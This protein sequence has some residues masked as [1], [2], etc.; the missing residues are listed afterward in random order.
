MKTELQN[1]DEQTLAKLDTVMD[2]L[3]GEI[4]SGELMGMLD[5]TAKGGVKQTLQNCVRIFRHDP[6]FYRKIRYNILTQRP[7]IIGDVPWSRACKGEVL[8]NSDLRAIHLYIS[9]TYGITSEHVVDEAMYLVADECRYHPV[10]D[11]LN[12]LPAWDGTERIRFALHHF[13]GADTSDYTY[14]LLKFFMLGAIARVFHPGIKF[15]YMLCLVGDQGAGKSSFF[16]LLAVRDE[17]F[18]D[19]LKNLEAKDVYEKMQGHW[20][21]E[22]SEMMAAINARTNEAIKSFLSRQ[23]ET[24]RTKYERLPEDRP[25]QCVFAG[26]TNKKEFLPN[27][28]TGNRR[29]L[30]IQC[31]EEQAEVFI[32]DDE[33]ASRA[34]IDQMWAEAMETYRSGPVSL[35]L[36]KKMEDH[37]RK[38]Q[39]D[40]VPEDVDAGLILSY[41]QDTKEEK[42]CSKM[43]FKE[44]L[45]NEYTQPLRWQTNDI[46]EIVNQLI[47]RGD[48]KGWRA[49]DNPR[50]FGNGYGTQRGWEKVPENVNENVNKG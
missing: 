25:R 4:P 1:I 23:K 10:R 24:Y 3:Q 28:R 30:P 13:L 7:D 48:L 36:S 44:A 31:H 38:Y 32:L 29:F 6:V 8:S 20:I 16:R 39:E 34:Y 47:R 33:D 18:C 45:G 9:E 14:E 37:I 40:F 17:W 5:Q 49:F 22:M 12:H 15:D 21:I 2:E 42:V 35:K 26:T 19:D 43:L 27:D 41:M 46:C 50:R 11:Y